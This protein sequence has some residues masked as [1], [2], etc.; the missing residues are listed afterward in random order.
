MRR[1]RRRSKCPQAD[2]ARPAAPSNAANV[3][4]VQAEAVQLPMRRQLTIEE[5][6]CQLIGAAT[7]A[8]SV[9]TKSQTAARRFQDSFLGGPQLQKGCI[10]RRRFKRGKRS[11][12]IGAEIAL[13][14]RQR[15][16]P[17]AQ[18][19]QVHARFNPSRDRK[20]SLVTAM[21][22]VEMQIGIT[23]R[24]QTRAAIDPGT[25]PNDIHRASQIGSQQ[26][27]ERRTTLVTVVVHP[28]YVYLVFA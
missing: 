11:E 7:D 28:P 18:P 2:R 10:P 14:Y 4:P 22:P 9:K 8:Q 26:R 12:F 20:Q 13:G 6:Q 27:K 16:R 17:R 5:T 15:A 21:C 25:Q 3:L 23:R 24:F 19:F 1:S